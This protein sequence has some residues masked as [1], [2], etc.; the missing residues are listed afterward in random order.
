MGS[1]KV[2]KAFEKA[3]TTE[4]KKV[5]KTKSRAQIMNPVRREILQYLSRHPCSNASRISRA[6][7]KSIHTVEWHL[8]KLIE[9]GFVSQGLEGVGGTGLTVVKSRIAGGNG[10]RSK[11]AKGARGTKGRMGENK[12]SES[13]SA[14]YWPR[15]FLDNE[16]LEIMAAFGENKTRLTFL[17]ILENPGS[18][19]TEI[20][21]GLETSHQ[22]IGRVTERLDRLGLINKVDDGRFRRYYPSDLLATKRDGFGVRAKR[23]RDTFLAKLESE[24]LKPKVIRSSETEIMIQLTRGKEKALLKLSCD[25]FSTI[26]L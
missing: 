2:G 17:Y 6:V 26:L 19:Q 15:G 1:K 14:V 21:V 23:F 12:R 20:G 16:D 24:G 8:K 7:N 22:S 3:I 13:R 4:P 11:E 10:G 5:G 25:P 18:T 9:A